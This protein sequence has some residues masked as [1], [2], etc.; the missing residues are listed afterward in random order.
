[1]MGK[2]PEV[3][4][5]DQLFLKLHRSSFEYTHTWGIKDSLGLLYKDAVHKVYLVVVVRGGG[6]GGG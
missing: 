5:F 2:S 1:M 3:L 4:N 6:G